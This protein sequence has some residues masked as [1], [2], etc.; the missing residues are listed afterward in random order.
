MKIEIC[1][2]MLQSWLQ[3][4]KQCEVVQTNWMVSPLR[5][6]TI[7]DADLNDVDKFMKEV[8]EQL[9]LALE[10]DEAVK[11]ALQ[12][13][14]DEELLSEEES[15]AKKKKT[16]KS[17]KLD[18]FKKSTAHQ[19]VTQCEID[20]VGCKLDDG[21]TDR[22]YL[23]DSAF[24]KS[25]LGY[26]NPEATVLKK[27]VRALA[28]SVIIFGESVP[29]TVLFA[30]PKCGNTLND[31]IENVVDKLRTILKVHP[32]YS[33]IE[34]ELYFNERFATDIYLPL[35]NELNALNN[36]NDLFMRAM[37]L[38]KLAET[39]LSNDATTVAPVA[40]A[41]SAAPA[42]PS[43]RLPKGY[44]EKRVFGI[45]QGVIKS[46][47]MTSA[48]LNDLQISVYAKKHF[49]LSTYPVLLKETEFP[50]SGWA[51]L[52]FYGKTLTIAGESY[53][54]CSQMSTSS[55]GLLETWA[56]AL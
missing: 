27:I 34:I 35:I 56:N 9:D 5:V 6:R 42:T 40:P 10:N 39:Y 25:G 47:K 20:V 38:S 11:A 31:K 2:Q 7:P 51:R 17:K 8:Q 33:N 4:C 29:V 36:D 54:V 26:H 53:L 49:K 30:A 23:A 13:S 19:F 43:V 16:R 32:R 21:I 55:I 37:N 45:L 15:P 44:N 3:H 18:I 52:R 12:E 24:H 1:E 22:I 46:G 48:V 28:V 41:A 50:F 14:F